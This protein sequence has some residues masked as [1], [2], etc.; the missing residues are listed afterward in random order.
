MDLQLAGRVALV[1]GGNGLI[2][3]AIVERL[4]AEEAVVVSASRRTRDG[5]AL[6]ANDEESVNVGFSRLLAQHD[7]LDCLIVASGSR[8]QTLD[9]QS[10]DSDHVLSAI[11][12][13]AISFLRLASAA[14]PAMLAT[15][16]GRIIG[17]SGQ[18][19]FVTGG[20]AASV[21][22]AAMA[23]IA[24]N[25]AD[26][27]AGSGVTVNTLSPGQVVATLTQSGEA[28]ASECRPRDIADLVAF[29]ASPLAERIS[30]ESI[31]V[32]HRAPGFASY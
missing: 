23:L 26:S 16:Y 13:K 7:R 29:M 18:N 8:A 20:V 21:R 31:A 4:R 25:L 24:K 12:H 10:S 30:G 2:G 14:L 28:S 6:D 32:G 22:N 3:S 27:V 1:I 11:D 19:A 5:I 15:G 9:S 17:I